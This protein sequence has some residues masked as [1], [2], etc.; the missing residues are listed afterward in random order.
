MSTARPEKEVQEEV[1]LLPPH[2]VIIENDDYHSFEFVIEVLVKAVHLAPQKASILTREAHER[3]Q[4]VVWTGSKEVAE[5]KLERIQS[6]H[7]V[8]DSDGAKL[9]PVGCRIEPAPGS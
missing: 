4:A 2:N 7:E 6:L 1:R 8:R 3:G 5:L 9:G